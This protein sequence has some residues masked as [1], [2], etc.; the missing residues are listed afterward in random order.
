M[1]I[2]RWDPFRDLLSIQNEMNRLFSRTYGAGGEMP[3]AEPAGTWVP[4][5]DVYETDEGLHRR[6]RAARSDLR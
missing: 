1:V 5:L 6:R 3:E 2:R 4:A